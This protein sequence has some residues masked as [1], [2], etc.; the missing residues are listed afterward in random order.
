MT[1][2]RSI[3][4]H[5]AASNDEAK[6]LSGDH[7][8]ARLTHEIA[9]SLIRGTWLKF[10]AFH[11]QCF[12]CRAICSCLE[13]SSRISAPFSFKLNSGERFYFNIPQTHLF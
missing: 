6:P 10:V 12:L 11:Q 4:S 5:E 2:I 1:G 9:D 3:G 8:D 7:R 13:T